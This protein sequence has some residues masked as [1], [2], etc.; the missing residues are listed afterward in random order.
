MDSMVSRHG[1]CDAFGFDEAANEGGRF[2]TAEFVVVDLLMQSSNTQKIVIAFGVVGSIQSDVKS[3]D[4][5]G[6]LMHVS[7]LLSCQL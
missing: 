1:S 4:S 2:E 3:G 7:Q 5:A 6:D